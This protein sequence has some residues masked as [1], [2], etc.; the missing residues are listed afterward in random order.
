MRV[1]CIIGLLAVLPMQEDRVVPV[2][3]EPR[4]R[5]V[6]ETPGTRILDIQI[7]PGDTTLFHTHS[8]PILYL[9]MSS[10][11]TRSQT[12]GGDWS[13]PA[14][15]ST[16]SASSA[17][18][19]RPAPPARAFSVTSYAERPLTHR[20]NNLGP[21]LFRLIGITNSSPGDASTT[22]SSDFASTPEV[23]N[24]WFRAYRWT[25]KSQGIEHRH[26]NP[27]VIVVATGSA[28]VRSAATPDAQQLS[29]PGAFAFLGANVVHTLQAMSA[30]SEVMEVEIRRPR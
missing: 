17:P 30:N 12:L 20:V 8:D 21:S 28:A 16:P 10:S 7:V 1:A 3:E 2:H 15:A 18:A 14:A 27:V 9:T 25:P 5:L 26:G 4:H 6:F 29:E 22:A 23:T 19:P 24:R 13:A 11:Q